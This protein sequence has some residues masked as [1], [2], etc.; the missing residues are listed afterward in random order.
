VA[1]GAQRHRG[2]LRSVAV[3]VAA[4]RYRRTKGDWP[5]TVSDLVPAYLPAVPLDPCDG[6]PIRLK[7]TEF[8]ITVYCVGP[9]RR[10][11][12]GTI[13][14]EAREKPGTDAGYQLWD[15]DKRHQPAPPPPPDDKGGVAPPAGAVPEPPMK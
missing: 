11:D 15:V 8:G 14:R 13:D 9:D 5:E 4:E 12:G 6:K 2:S 3:L 10:D 7:R 1:Q